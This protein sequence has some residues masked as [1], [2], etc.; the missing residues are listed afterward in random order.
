MAFNVKASLEAVQTYFLK[1]GYFG[2]AEIGER[3]IPPTGGQL[4]ADIWMK[5][6]AVVRVYANGGTGE[7]HQVMVRIYADLF[8]VP[9][10]Q[11]ELQLAEVVQKVLSDLLAD[12]QLGGE[13]REIDAGGINGT[14]VRTDWGHVEMGGKMYRVAD[15]T[16]PLSVDDSATMAP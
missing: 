3:K 12:Y 15:I 5:S 16:L 13:V 8:G 11:Q 10:A 2:T 4:S 1:G 6:A 7:S 14:P 9:T